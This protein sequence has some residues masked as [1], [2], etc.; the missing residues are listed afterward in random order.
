MT[1][2]L[3]KHFP[4][5]RDREELEVIIENNYHLKN[6]FNSWEKERQIE[7]L[8]FCTGVRGIK[9]LYDTFFKEAL[10]PEYDSERLEQLLSVFLKRRVKI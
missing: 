9:I 2:K 6:I 8:N 10:N 4:M 1:S 5:I 3:K 7:F